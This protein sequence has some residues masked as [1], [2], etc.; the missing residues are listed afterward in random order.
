MNASSYT[1]GSLRTRKDHVIRAKWIKA[2]GE[3]EK[4]DWNEIKKYLDVKSLDFLLNWEG[5]DAIYKK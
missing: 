5:N 1:E 4:V 2:G 3:F